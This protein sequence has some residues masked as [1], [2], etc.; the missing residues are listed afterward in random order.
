MKSQYKQQ[1]PIMKL[2]KEM[3]FPVETALIATVTWLEV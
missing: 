2:K 1:T 3:W